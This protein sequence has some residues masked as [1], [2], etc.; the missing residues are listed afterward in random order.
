MLPTTVYYPV[1]N[2]VGYLQGTI[3]GATFRQP[4]YADGSLGV[5]RRAYGPAPGPV[6]ECSAVDNPSSMIGT[7][8]LLPHGRLLIMV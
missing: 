1:E 2:P 8:K 7:P 3:D 4:V 6:E 5:K